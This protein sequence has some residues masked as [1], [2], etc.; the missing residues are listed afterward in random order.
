MVTP[1]VSGI[2][3]EFLT[4]SDSYGGYFVP[5]KWCVLSKANHYTLLLAHTLKQVLTPEDLQD[6]M[7]GLKRQSADFFPGALATAETRP[8]A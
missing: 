1:S 3:F 4:L 5:S 7:R 2:F 8:V 6:A